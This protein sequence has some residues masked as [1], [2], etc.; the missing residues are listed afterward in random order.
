LY[1]PFKRENWREA[2]ST[3]QS[4]TNKAKMPLLF[5]S[6]LIETKQSGWSI[7]SEDAYL[8]SPLSAYPVNT[9][10]IPLPLSY[11]TTSWHYLETVLLN[12]VLAHSRFLVVFKRYIG[13]SDVDS[14]LSKILALNGYN[15][16][17]IGNYNGV[18]LVFY[19]IYPDDTLI[20][21]RS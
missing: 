1:P 10:I 2:L 4:L 15:R 13:N 19:S 7:Y 21:N 20:L 16:F 12:K 5:N 14:W 17:L 9:D 6:G 3:A 8:F 11:D 18:V